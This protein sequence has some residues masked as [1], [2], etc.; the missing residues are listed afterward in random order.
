MTRVLL[1]GAD[2]FV[3]HHVWTRLTQHNEATV[4]T[5]SRRGDVHPDLQLD[6]TDSV[7]AVGR[8]LAEFAPDAVVNCAGSAA[9]E[10]AALAANNV[11]ATANLV[12]A[13]L[14]AETRIR[15]VH[16][17]SAA[18]YGRA[19]AGVA[20]AEDAPTRPV[21]PYGLSK[22]AAT[23]L[24]RTAATAGLDAVVLRLATP[25]GPDA[26]PTGVAGRVVGQ[27]RQIEAEGGGVTTGPLDDVRD[28]VDV[29][30]VADAVSAAALR[31]S[32]AP[33]LPHVLNVGSGRATPVR[34]MVEAL[35]ALAG[36]TG[37]LRTDGGGSQRATAMPWQ[38]CDISAIK[39]ALAWHPT[40]DLETSLRDLWESSASLVPC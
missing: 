7:A 27:L 3:G 11:V 34:T 1:L 31:P 18:E 23:R 2:G 17:G 12:D 35:L 21:T 14:K 32:D 38:Q 5:V 24:V 9:G 16:L 33:P 20:I 15:L 19:P 36:F 13:L 29:R 10:P 40:R 30:D 8:A 39:S 25:V 28:F 22:L 37:G 4:V 6:L 26:P